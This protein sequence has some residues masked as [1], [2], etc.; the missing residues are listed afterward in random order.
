MPECKA[1]RAVS[2]LF[3][4]RAVSELFYSSTGENSSTV[5]ALSQAGYSCFLSCFHL[6][7]SS[8]FVCPPPYRGH[9][10]KQLGVKGKIL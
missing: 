5:T 3:L 10:S 6:F 7:L 4:R 8:C 1:S 2:E 9:N